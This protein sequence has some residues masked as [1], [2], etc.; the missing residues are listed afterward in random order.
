M[1]G[2]SNGS[3]ISSFYFKDL[4]SMACLRVV[5]PPWYT[6]SF[7]RRSKLKRFL[8]PRVNRLRA[9]PLQ[10]VEYNLGRT[11][12]SELAERETSLRSISSF[13]WPSWG[14]ACSLPS[15][16]KANAATALSKTRTSKMHIWS[17]KPGF[18]TIFSISLI[19]RVGLK[20]VRDGMEWLL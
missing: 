6:P 15:Q 14:T 20:Y 18:H 17:K 9:V 4:K 13:A 5:W 7:S 2:K 8:S 11:G 19:A 3:A 10:S 1:Y 16:Q 12:E